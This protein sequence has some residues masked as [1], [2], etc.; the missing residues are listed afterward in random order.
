M[1]NQ[2]RSLN[3]VYFALFIS[4]FA[5]VLL[6]AFFHFPFEIPKNSENKTLI[7]N[8]AIF[9]L[10]SLLKST[11]EITRELPKLQDSYQLV[12]RKNIPNCI[13][14]VSNGIPLADITCIAI[15]GI[16]AIKRKWSDDYRIKF[17]GLKDDL[18]NYDQI[19]L[20]GING[21]ILAL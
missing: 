21:T 7:I 12:K 19:A 6:T 4:V 10:S 5:H 1:L 18:E 11:T 2:K 17:N 16:G 20:S 3:R 9:D 15:K 8:I 14:P 13:I